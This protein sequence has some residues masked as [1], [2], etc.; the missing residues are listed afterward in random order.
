MENLS[1][2]PGDAW[3]SGVEAIVLVLVLSRGATVLVIESRRLP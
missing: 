3:R 1:R 2:V